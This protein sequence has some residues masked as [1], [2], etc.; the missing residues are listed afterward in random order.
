MPPTP[1]PPARVLLPAAILALAALLLAAWSAA[2]ALAD[3]CPDAWITAKVKSRLF[4]DRGLG[5]FKINVDTEQ[6]V[7]TLVGCVGTD[8]QAA[9][10]VEIAG[11]VKKV[12]DVRSRLGRCPAGSKDGKEEGG[13]GVDKCPDALITAEVKSLIAAEEGLAA[14]R[15]NVDTEECIV[16]LKG[17]VKTDDQRAG[18]ARA[19]RRGKGVRKV[20]NELSLCGD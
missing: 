4:G 3:D 13:D 19:A 16:S 8:E 10:A 5:V 1:P 15:I 12:R 7:V 9:R 20:R 2:P 6:C 18:A 11:K 14:F 17:C